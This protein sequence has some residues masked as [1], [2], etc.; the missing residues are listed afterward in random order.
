MIWIGRIIAM[1]LGL[2]LLALLLLTL[3][4]LQVNDTFLKPSYYTDQLAEAGIYE[5][6][7]NDLLT[8]A[9]NEA[10][11]LDA[12]E[13]TIN[14]E[15]PEENPIVTSGLSTERIVQAINRAVPPEYLQDLVEQSFDQFGGYLTAERDEFELTIRAGEQVAIIVDEVKLL[16]GEADAYSL[17]FDEAVEPELRKA[18]RVDLPLGVKASSD[19]LVQ[20]ARRIMPPE[21]VQQ[22]VENTL[23]E[24][25]AYM[26]GESDTF[27]VEIGLSDRI[28]IAIGE[29]KSILRE[30]DAA[31]ILYE[32][33]VEPTVLESLGQGVDLTFG[34]TVTESEVLGALRE[35]APTEWVEEQV[36]LIIDEAGP[37][38]AGKTDSF[39]MEISLVDNKRLAGVIIEDMVREKL[40]T[41]ID[42]LPTCRTVAE[43][44]AAT[45][46]GVGLL[47]ACV[48]PNLS[49]NELIDASGID[50]GDTVQRS[51]LG[52]IPN[53]V[54]FSDARIR[55][56]LVLAGA[57]NNIELM[58]DLREF[59]RDGC[60]YTERDL[61]SPKPE[62]ALCPSVFNEDVSSTIDDV[63]SFLSDGF[64][65][66]HI[67]FREDLE[68]IDR[69]L[70]GDGVLA[71]PREEL[72]F[73]PDT[74]IEILD[75]SRN[76]LTWTHDNRWIFYVPLVLLL[77][78]IGFLGGRGWWGRLMWAASFLLVTAAIVVVAAGPVWDNVTS[79][80][81]DD[82]R[83][84]A[85]EK[86]SQDV[87]TKL[88]STSRLALDKGFDI[89]ESVADDFASG[90]RTSAITLAFIAI[91]AVAATVFKNTIIT[92]ISRMTSDIGKRDD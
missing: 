26:I 25:T 21:W 2:L 72:L 54:S 44:V 17:L 89:A 57:G 84:E 8:S 61:V 1:P 92:A 18:A 30:M 10:R 73:I 63:R 5:F 82:Q 7:L 48:P 59:I 3:F 11:E 31:D 87:D 79:G 38:L 74:A 50:I 83:A 40:T 53:M 76:W 80:R 81:F 55:S 56:A 13:F 88:P 69:D 33:V 75:F 6:A 49:L 77:V 65:Y 29:I 34:V 37:Y 60:T 36:D 16:L 24:I 32:Q 86:I 12:S 52:Q 90:I 45:R 15:T 39:S 64:T 46:G 58:D 43:A 51:V 19:R 23:D 20:A 68:N 28:D 62:I 9:L 66:T 78:I 27:K 22:L 35:V 91:V 47:P 42:E 4:T 70:G 14:G 67:D 85:I 41:L 71:P